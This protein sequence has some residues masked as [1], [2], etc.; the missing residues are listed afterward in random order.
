[1]FVNDYEYDGR[2]AVVTGG[3]GSGMGAAVV[4]GLVE[5]GA[6]VHVLDLKEP[7]VKVASHQNA[8]LK[9]PDAI[10]SALAAIGGPIHTLF[11]CVGVP[12]NHT[13]QLDTMLINYAGVRHLT[14][15]VTERMPDGGT[16]ST[17]TSQ[18]GVRWADRLGPWKELAQTA[19]YAAAKAWFEA[20]PDTYCWHPYS[21]SKEAL[22]VW[23]MWSSTILAKRAI[24][25]NAILPGPTA[26]PMSPDFVATTSERFMDNY[27]IALGRH[28]T[29]REQ[30]DVLLFLNSDRA[31]AIT[32]APILTDGGG[33]SGVTTGQLSVPEL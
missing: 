25:Q 2:T 29:P 17:V 24:R 8:D 3:G 33:T 18:G 5:L 12:G 32:G 13:S 27:P 16:I 6:E 20:N 23:T 22:I 14:D 1:M 10:D 28:Q 11:N 4:E 19:D 9:D 31:G 7:S 26:T 15:R 21:A 30:A